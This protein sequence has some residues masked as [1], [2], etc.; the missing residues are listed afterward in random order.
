MIAIIGAI[1]FFVIEKREVDWLFYSL[2]SLSFFA[3]IFSIVLG[4]KGIDIARKKAYQNVLDLDC[5]KSKFNLQA[6]FCLLGIFFCILSYAF[7]SEKVENNE[8]LKKLNEN[9]LKIIKLN[10]SK[11]NETEIL[12]E[13]IKILEIKINELEIKK[14]NKK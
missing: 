6:V 13:K 9:I 12:T 5:S 14:A 11:I 3:F 10:E 7:T 8:E 4:G 1:F 2:I